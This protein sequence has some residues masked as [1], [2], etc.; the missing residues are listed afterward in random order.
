MF[1]VR[2]SL[3]KCSC[4]GCG[5]ELGMGTSSSCQGP[6]SRRPS[7]RVR[8]F[9]PMLRS[10]SPRQKRQSRPKA[11]MSVQQ[12]LRGRTCAG[13]R[14]SARRPNNRHRCL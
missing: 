5:A 13:W 12:K 11:A 7:E 9:D 4:S 14:L 6:V 2:P 10:F 3:E 8:R 1:G